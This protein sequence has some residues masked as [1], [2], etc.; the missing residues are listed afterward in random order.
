M[1]NAL[2]QVT[3]PDEVSSTA[4]SASAPVRVPLR[5]PE[6]KLEPSKEL[7]SSPSPGTSLSP[8][9]GTSLSSSS[10]GHNSLLNLSVAA[11]SVTFDASANHPHLRKEEAPVVVDLTPLGQARAAEQV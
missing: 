8:S 9:P 4:A 5:E 6:P 7:A 2:S 3:K 1:S 10:V 11:A